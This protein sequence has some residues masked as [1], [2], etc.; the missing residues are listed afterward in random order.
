MAE[1]RA[2]SVIAAEIA[3]DWE[4]PYFGAVPYL[5]AMRYIT[6][7]DDLYGCDP[8]D[9]VVRYFLANAGRWRGPTAVRIK[10]ELNAMLRAL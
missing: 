7:L 3:K 4:E 2:I 9:H 8:A 1:S 10:K 5:D 6:T